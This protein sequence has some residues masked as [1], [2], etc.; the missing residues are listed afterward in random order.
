M[1]DFQNLTTIKLLYDYLWSKGANENTPHAAG[2]AKVGAGSEDT[3][4]SDTG[5]E[6]A[7]QTSSA[8]SLSG[9]ESPERE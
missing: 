8:S 7:T 6:M 1:S 5:D 2:V 9:E 3:S 4:D